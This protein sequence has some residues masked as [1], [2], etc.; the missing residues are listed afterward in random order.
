MHSRPKLILL[1]VTLNLVFGFWLSDIL[2][3]S[4][5]AEACEVWLFAKY[6]VALEV[7]L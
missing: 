3:F 7:S 1:F 5:S 2:A 4:P 6:T